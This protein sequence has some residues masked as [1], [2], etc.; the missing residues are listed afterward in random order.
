VKEFH[1]SYAMVSRWS[2][3]QFWA[4]GIAGLIASV[5]SRIWGRRPVYVVSILL[6]FIGVLWN[7]FSKSGNSFLGARFVEGLGL[8][9]FEMLVPTSIGD[10]FFVS[11]ASA[12][13]R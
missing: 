3:W 4:S 5:V 6:V 11:M 1:T 9:A 8:G 13:K 7:G 12:R 2:G 10:L